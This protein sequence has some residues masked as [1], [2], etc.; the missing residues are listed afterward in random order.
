[1][2]KPEEPKFMPSGEYFFTIS[3][4]IVTLVFALTTNY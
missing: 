2:F 3:F 1:M 4:L